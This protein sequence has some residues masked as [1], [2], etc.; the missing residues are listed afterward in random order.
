MH[1]PFT[2]TQNLMLGFGFLGL[3]GLDL[4]NKQLRR[5]LEQLHST[6]T[7]LAEIRNH[8]SGS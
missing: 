2:E 4:L 3:Y 7:L 6:N 8:R 5:I 1:W